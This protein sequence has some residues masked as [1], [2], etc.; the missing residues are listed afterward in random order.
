MQCY[1]N[2]PIGFFIGPFF[3]G[4]HGGAEKRFEMFRKKPGFQSG[5]H[6]ANGGLAAVPDREPGRKRRCSWRHELRLRTRPEQ[7]AQP[8]D[9]PDPRGRTKKG[10]FYRIEAE[11][12]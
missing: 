4:D 11:R 1:L 2:L 10:P 12:K 8:F 6:W 9:Q 7:G 5:Y 3:P